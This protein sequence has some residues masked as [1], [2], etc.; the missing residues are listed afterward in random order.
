MS[1]ISKNNL[2]LTGVL[3]VAADASLSGKGVDGWKAPGA[4]PVRSVTLQLS[5]I[6]KL[7]LQAPSALHAEPKPAPK[8]VSV[9]L[10]TVAP[11]TNTKHSFPTVV[12]LGK[13]FEHLVNASGHTTAATLWS[14]AGEVL[15]G[16]NPQ[17]QTGARLMRADQLD[18]ADE[19][20]GWAAR[21]LKDEQIAQELSLNWQTVREYRQSAFNK[22]GFYNYKDIKDNYGLNKFATEVEIERLR[23]TSRSNAREK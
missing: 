17:L 3:P 6:R 15:K 22:L 18:K 8:P 23:R 10:P 7:P 14:A 1:L 12:D 20:V 19:V 13:R 2:R 21:G 16:I 4:V 11:L 5:G 9:V